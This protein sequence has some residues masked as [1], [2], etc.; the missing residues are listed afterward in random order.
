MSQA[1][2][3]WKDGYICAT[4]GIAIG[5]TALAILPVLIVTA[6]SDSLFPAEIFPYYIAGTMAF[7]TYFVTGL[8]FIIGLPWFLN[9]YLSSG[10]HVSIMRSGRGFGGTATELIGHVIKLNWSRIKMTGYIAAAFAILFMAITSFR[11]SGPILDAIAIMVLM[12]FSIVCMGLIASGFRGFPWP[13]Y[14]VFT[15]WILSSLTFLLFWWSGILAFWTGELYIMWLEGVGIT[16][17]FD[18]DWRSSELYY[19]KDMIFNYE[20][21]E[22]IAVPVLL[23]VAIVVIF[24]VGMVLLRKRMC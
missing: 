22:M 24:P 21:F 16:H 1:F 9:E 8:D 5:T 15:C 13:S 3:E 12:W 4:D 10:E 17:I 20:R 7:Y 11:H 19:A 14:A 2:E 23:L 6:M 18:T